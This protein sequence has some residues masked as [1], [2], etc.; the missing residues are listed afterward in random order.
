[1][2]TRIPL[3][4]INGTISQL[5]AG[6]TINASASEVDVISATNANAGAITIGQ[7]V[8]VSASGSVD[9]A[10]ANTS[11][12]AKVVGLVR[13]SSVAS[14]ASGFVQ[15]D[16]VLTNSDWTSVVGE[17]SLTTGSDYFLSPTSAGMLT[18]S[19]PST[20]GQYSVYVGRALSATDLEISIERPISL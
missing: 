20:A 10:R 19:A 3:V 17:A 13:S 5:P 6:D 11:T 2:A 8:Y 1:M 9:L 16:G 4:L 18:S 12:T 7:P 14:G 15:T